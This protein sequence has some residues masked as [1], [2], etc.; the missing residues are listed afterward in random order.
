MFQILGLVV[1]SCKACACVIF[2]LLLIFLY[3]VCFFSASPLTGR[4]RWTRILMLF[5]SNIIDMLY[6][7]DALFLCFAVDRTVTLD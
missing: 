7:H 3:G 4:L 2:V 1:P 6:F 5:C